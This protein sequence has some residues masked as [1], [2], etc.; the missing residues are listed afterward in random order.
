V[1]LS[2]GI[3]TLIDAGFIIAGFPEEKVTPFI[4][5][6]L[7]LHLLFMLRKVRSTETRLL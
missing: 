4:A 7:F 6:I 5:V 1:V 3:L 2:G